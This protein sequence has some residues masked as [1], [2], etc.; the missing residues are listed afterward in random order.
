[1][2]RS[3]SP[4][5]KIRG[6]GTALIKMGKRTIHETGE[7]EL[8]PSPEAGCLGA[9]GVSCMCWSNSGSKSAGILAWLAISHPPSQLP[10]G[11]LCSTSRRASLKR[12]PPPPAPSPSPPSPGAN[13]DVRLRTRSSTRHG[14]GRSHRSG[15]RVARSIVPTG[16]LPLAASMTRRSQSQP[17]E[18]RSATRPKPV[19]AL[20]CSSTSEH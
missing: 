18:Q 2:K 15:T 12:C 17:S 13:D 6:L 9:R 5:E 16:K 19:R 1:M 10:R 3:S 8:R 4:P 11:T 20:R 14:N 7:A